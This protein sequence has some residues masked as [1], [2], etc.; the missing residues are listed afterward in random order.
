MAGIKNS[1]VWTFIPEYMIHRDATG[2]PQQLSEYI[3]VPHLYGRTDSYRPL[4]NNHSGNGRKMPPPLLESRVSRRPTEFRC[5]P[6]TTIGPIQRPSRCYASKRLQSWRPR[7]RTQ[8]LSST[9]ISKSANSQLKE[10]PAA[11]KPSPPPNAPTAPR[12]YR[13]KPSPPPNAPTAPLAD[14][15]NQLDKAFNDMGVG[16]STINIIPAPFD[17][18]ISDTQCM[19]QQCPIG[20]SHPE[21]LYLHEGR[22]SDGPHDFFGAANPPP[23]LWQAY[24]RLEQLRASDHDLVGLEQFM[25]CHPPH[26]E[27]ASERFWPRS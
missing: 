9:V 26:L 22:L 10:Q 14:R 20:E 12:A 7:R 11:I 5:G 21:G 27:L 19:H 17:C 15:L 3:N 25:L 23:W 18:Y 13:L 6:T 16:D 24:G 2:C 4:Y 8:R 1:G